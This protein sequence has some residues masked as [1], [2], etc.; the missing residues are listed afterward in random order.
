[1]FTAVTLHGVP[2]ALVAALG[3]NR[4]TIY[5]ALFQAGAASCAPAWQP[6]EEISRTFREPCPQAGEGCVGGGARAGGEG[7][8]GGGGGGL[9]HGGGEFKEHPGGGGET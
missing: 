8:G 5:K 1:M 3:S 6:I 4:N 9:P 7:A 2:T